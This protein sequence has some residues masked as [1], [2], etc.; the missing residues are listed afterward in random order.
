[1]TDAFWTYKLIVYAHT[2]KTCAQNN[3]VIDHVAKH[4]CTPEDIHGS[5]QIYMYTLA[6]HIQAYLVRQHTPKVLNTQTHEENTYSLPIC[7]YRTLII[8]SFHTVIK[9]VHTQTH[10]HTERMLT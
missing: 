4:A 3:C 10:I 8:H 9:Y 5:M 7:T 6:M 2:E 1:M